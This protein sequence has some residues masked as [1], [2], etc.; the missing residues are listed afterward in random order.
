M[1][2]TEIIEA[3]A[4]KLGNVPAD[5]IAKITNDMFVLAATRMDSR[6]G[7]Q[8]YGNYVSMFTDNLYNE[9][10]PFHELLDGEKKLRAL[11][12]A[13]A[14]YVLYF[15]ALALK[16]INKGSVIQTK[17]TFGE[18]SI[19]PSPIAQFISMREQYLYEGDQLLKNYSSSGGV[20]FLSV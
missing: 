16:E 10:L 11:E 5:A 17:I 4:K 3:R 20:T 14:Y 6:M 18:G 15:L 7:S 13:E 12:T 19:N 8:S 1:T 2:H 9:S